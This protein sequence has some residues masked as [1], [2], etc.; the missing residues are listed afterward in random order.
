LVYKNRKVNPEYYEKKCFID[1]DGYKILKLQ[2]KGKQKNYPIHR[3]IAYAYLGLDINNPKKVIDHVDRDKLNNQDSNLRVV[4][5]QENCFNR[6]A[7]GYRKRGNKF[8]AII[9]LNGKAIYLDYYD[10]TEE[11]RNAYLTAKEIHHIIN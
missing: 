11:A 1:K 9:T 3:I 7:K 2:H 4:S 5:Q 6:G 8:Q 10:T